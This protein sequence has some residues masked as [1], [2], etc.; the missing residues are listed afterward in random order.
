MGIFD[1]L[2]GNRKQYPAGGLAI[3]GAGSF[4]FDIVGEGNYQPALDRI[5]GG[6]SE[7]GYEYECVAVL[8]EEPSNPYD[9]NAVK[10]TID[11]QTVGYL[12]RED[13]VDYKHALADAG[14]AGRAVEV[15]AIVVGGWS[16]RRGDNGHYGVKL[17]MDLPPDFG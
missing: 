2:F 14:L 15:D 5:C 6:K 3:V 9:R 17:D 16:R 10:V 8:I 13:A 12:A 4:D 1:W 11:G 7:D